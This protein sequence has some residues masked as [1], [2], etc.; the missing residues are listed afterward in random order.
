MPRYYNNNSIERN[1]ST[2]KTNISI[3]YSFLYYL[4][5]FLLKQFKKFF[6][7]NNKISNFTDVKIYPCPYY[8]KYLEKY[9]LVP[10]FCKK[11]NVHQD[12]QLMC[13][14]YSFLTLL[15][16]YIKNNE[17]KIKKQNIKQEIY[18]TINKLNHEYS[19]FKYSQTQSLQ[20]SFY[21]Y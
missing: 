3:N 12:N 16:Y 11:C 2:R 15:Y 5:R 20:K 6:K 7:A 17:N 13:N 14:F 4:K 9:E 10:N 21:K 18:K 1:F 8:K 19:I